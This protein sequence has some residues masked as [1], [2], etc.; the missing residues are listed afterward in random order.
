M[1]FLKY[2]CKS[3]LITNRAVTQ[4]NLHLTMHG[5]QYRI[6]WAQQK[7]EHFGK[8]KCTCLCTSVFVVN[9]E[10]TSQMPHKEQWVLGCAVQSG[11]N[12][13]YICQFPH[14]TLEKTLNL[15]YFSTLR[16]CKLM[17]NTVL[18]IGQP[19]EL[20]EFDITRGKKSNE[21]KCLRLTLSVLET[22]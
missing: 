17:I 6:Q 10:G 20:W 15:S 7:R 12:S 8:H 4:L 3:L 1:H 11:Q 22:Q 16:I 21:T 13:T 2:A 18:L 9:T 5:C 19:C 14:K